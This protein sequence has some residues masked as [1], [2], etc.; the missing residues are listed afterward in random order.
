MTMTTF[1][2]FLATLLLLLNGMACGAE[3]GQMN[4]FDIDE[5][6]VPLASIMSG[7]P[8]R[9]GIP[10]VDAPRFVRANEVDFLSNRDRVMGVAHQGIV[11]AYPLRILNRHEIVNDTYAGRAEVVTFCPLCGSGIVFEGDINGTNMDFG[12]SGLL[13][14]SDVLLYDRQTESLWSQIMTRSI[15]GRMKGTY[16]QQIAASNTTWQDWRERHPDT[17]VMS[18]DTGYRFI[19][20]DDDPYADYKKSNRVWFPLTNTDKRLRKKEWVLGVTTESS[21]KAFPLRELY[22][23]ISPVQESVGA[24]Q[25]SI[26]FDEKN[27]TATAF[28]V[29]G[30]VLPSIQLYWFAW[31]AFHPDT[32][33]YSTRDG[34]K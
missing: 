34:D 6:L 25:V 14:N 13:H 15:S 31:A 26:E 1:R 11:K 9:D 7:G 32:E 3:N 21:A 20:Y 2:T 33:L 8:P 12:V 16:L 27:Q 5:P 4:G 19:D 28:D 22:R 29:D 18:T 17:L 23:R 24:T 10:A 30:T